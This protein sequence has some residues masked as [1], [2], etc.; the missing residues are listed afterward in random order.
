MHTNTHTHTRSHNIFN[1]P[2]AISGVG[3]VRPRRTGLT[4]L[5]HTV[6]SS[7]SHGHTR[8]RERTRSREEG[9][10][11]AT[12][13]DALFTAGYLMR[14]CVCVLLGIGLEDWILLTF[15]THLTPHLTQHSARGSGVIAG[16][17]G[18]AR[19]RWCT[20]AVRFSRYCTLN[21]TSLNRTTNQP[22]NNNKKHTTN[23][24][25][26]EVKR[27]HLHTGTHRGWFGAK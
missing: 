21:R 19:R 17:S 25:K 12:G 7:H 2:S 1:R 14:V 3:R 11:E 18:H 5:H 15:R 6:K 13:R 8:S 9:T 4:L 23:R 27:T 20:V 24:I 16:Y 26:K 22:T 10:Q